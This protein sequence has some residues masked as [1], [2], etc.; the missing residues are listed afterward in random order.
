VSVLAVDIGSSRTKAL[1]AGWDGRLI[2][3]RVA[4]TPRRS[5][6]PGELAY[7]AEAVYDT[8]EGL[9][10]DLAAVHHDDRVDTIAFSCLGTAM[11][12]LDGAGRPLGPALAPADA[13]PMA[14]PP[15]S[16]QLGMRARDLFAI[17]GSDPAAPSFLAHALWW[18]REHPRAMERL[19]RFRSL[20]GY[21]LARLCEADAEDR[22]WASRTMLFDLDANDW[23]PAIL[24][25]AGLPAAV[26]PLLEA[27]TTVHAV[28]PDVAT[29]L[30][31]APQAVVVVGGMDNGC[32]LLGS[33]DPDGAGLT[34]IV[35]T[36]EHI[37]GAADLGLVRRVAAATDAIVHAYP[38]ADRYV[39]MTRVPLGPLLE[40]A[41]A[42]D[43]RSLDSLLDDISQQ[44]QGRTL[45]LELEAV[46]QARRVGQPRKAI[47]Q[48]LLEGSAIVLRRFA[49]NWAALGLK[50]APVAV[51]GGGASHAAVLQ[52][53]A[54]MLGR[55][56]ATL[57]SDEAAGTGALRLASMAVRGLTPADACRLFSNPVAR[58]FRP[59]SGMA[60]NPRVEVSGA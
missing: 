53:K 25:A 13:R 44:P 31:L 19:A 21:A 38:L 59:R 58:T 40:R 24:A 35:G 50:A 20:R 56:L 4:V 6:E 1:L 41:A 5:V 60:V 39:T 30:G 16:E 11:V 32:S 52:L 14:A 23:S 8:I 15:V 36:Y 18:Q 7:P 54:N 3:V 34:N 49:D 9:V 43:E 37:A 42:G 12:P 10:A 45:P 47:L 28:R 29:R 57:A 22:S 46:D 2:E 33:S 27:S 48:A 51:V 55:P 26:L 17:T